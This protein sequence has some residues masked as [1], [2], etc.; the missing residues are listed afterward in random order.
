V[1]WTL[2]VR[3]PTSY[4]R[5]HFQDAPQAYRLIDTRPGDAIQ[6]LLTYPA[7]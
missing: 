4:H 1:L 6:V 3:P 5:F 7:K 2:Q